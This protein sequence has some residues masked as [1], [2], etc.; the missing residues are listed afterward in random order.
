MKSLSVSLT[1]T[2]IARSE[3]AGAPT[4][5]LSCPQGLAGILGAVGGGGVVIAEFAFRRFGN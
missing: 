3:V 4:I 1:S 5:R 2:A